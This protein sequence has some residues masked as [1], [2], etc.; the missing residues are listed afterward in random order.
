[1]KEIIWK[2]KNYRGFAQI[3]VVIKC[4]SLFPFFLFFRLPLF[5]SFFPLVSSFSSLSPSLLLPFPSLPFPSFLYV[6]SFGFSFPPLLSLCSLPSFPHSPPLVLPTTTFPHIAIPLP[7][8]LFFLVW[9]RFFSFFS[10][11][12]KSR[13][14]N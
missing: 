8:F 7:Y 3:L 9:K 10:I 12:I 14:I 2:S 1:M 6:S 11:Y 4:I 5:Y 13:E